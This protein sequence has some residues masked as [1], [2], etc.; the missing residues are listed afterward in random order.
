MISLKN[1]SVSVIFDRVIK[2][3]NGSIYGIK[4]TA[5]DPSIAYTAKAVNKFHEM[6]ENCGVEL[7]N[8][9]GEFKICEECAVANA[10]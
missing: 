3:L 7:L 4:M 9:K 10:R 8:M 5:N 1:G 2:T 6:I